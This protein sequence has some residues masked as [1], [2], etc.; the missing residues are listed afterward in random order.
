MFV[1]G[2]V[3]Q[4]TVQ[5]IAAG[6]LSR[7]G[8]LVKARTTGQSKDYW[9]K[10]GLLVKARTTGQSKDYWSRQGICDRY[11][12]IE[13]LVNGYLST[14]WQVVQ[15]KATCQWSLIQGMDTLS[16]LPKDVAS[17]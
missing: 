3:G 11:Y 9:S 6:K 13:L 14:S 5:V 12:C 7:Q 1:S 16:D 10:Q 17:L 8:L 15:G 4:A 2:K